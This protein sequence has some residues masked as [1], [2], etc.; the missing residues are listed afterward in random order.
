[1]TT[2]IVTTGRRAWVAP[3]ILDL[4][5]RDAIDKMA[6]VITGD[7]V[8]T[9]KPSPEAYLLAV[10]E[11]SLTLDPAAVVA[12]EDSVNGMR[13]AIAA[14]LASVVVPS[15]Y[16]RSDDF[17]EADL[18]VPEFDQAPVVDGVGALIQ[19]P[20]FRELVFGR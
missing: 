16:N 14:G 7:D 8:A 11:L 20:K 13:S 18:V 6:V 2:G 1:M 15:L 3:L 4:L 5:G 17:G 12:I 9:L 19:N 10:D